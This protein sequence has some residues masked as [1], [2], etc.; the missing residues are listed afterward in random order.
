[1]SN[2][3]TLRA[4]YEAFG[5]GDL[6]AVLENWHDDARWENPE[7]KQIPNPGEHE[8]RDAIRSLMM[9][10]PQHWERFDVSTDEFI[11]QGDTIV[12]LGHVDAKGRE[13]GSEAKL[14]FVHIV[15]FRDGKIERFQVLSDTALT[16]EALGTL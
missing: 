15:R 14:P 7:A 4:G 2:Q 11:E 16:A 6:D 13:T 12:V 10:T 5:R 9:E 1:M 3:D 8:G